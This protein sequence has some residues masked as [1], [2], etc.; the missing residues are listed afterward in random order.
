MQMAKP[1]RHKFGSIFL[2][3]VVISQ[4]R[5]IM[6]FFKPAKKLAKCWALCW[7]ILRNFCR[8]TKKQKTFNSLLLY[9]ILPTAF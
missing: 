6:N 3:I 9:C 5:V 7:F 4:R 2:A 1:L 8:T